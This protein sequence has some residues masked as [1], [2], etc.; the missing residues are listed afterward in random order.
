MAQERDTGQTP[1][2]KQPFSNFLFK[3]LQ[4]RRDLP[5]VGKQFPELLSFIYTEE[6]KTLPLGGIDFLR[7]HGQPVAVGTWPDTSGGSYYY[8]SYPQ[9]FFFFF[10]IW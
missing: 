7:S 4:K 5:T 1:G 2:E 8:L 6:N 3:P 10:L 9:Q